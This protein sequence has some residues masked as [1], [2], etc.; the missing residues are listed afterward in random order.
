[1][2]FKDVAIEYNDI[3]KVRKLNELENPITFWDDVRKIS[4]STKS[5]HGIKRWEILSEIRY[6]EILKNLKKED[7]NNDIRWVINTTKRIKIYL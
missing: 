4:K 2:K 5:D 1:M 6:K 7:T 3:S